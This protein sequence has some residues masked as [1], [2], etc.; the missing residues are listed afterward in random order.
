MPI[1][2]FY[3]FVYL[4]VYLTVYSVCKSNATTQPISNFKDNALIHSSKCCGIDEHLILFNNTVKCSKHTDNNNRFKIVFATISNY[5]KNG[6]C[7]E[8]CIDFLEENGKFQLYRL[9]GAMCNLEAIQKYNYF[10]K[11]CPPDFTY[12]KSTHKCVHGNSL[13]AFGDYLQVMKIG[14]S[15]C[16]VHDYAVAD[17]EGSF[18]IDND[19]K[20]IRMKSGESFNYGEFCIDLKHDMEKYLVRA[21]LKSDVICGVDKRRCLWKC[22]PDGEI[23]IQQQNKSKKCYPS[24]KSEINLNAISENV[25][26]NN[27]GMKL[28][29]LHFRAIIYQTN[30]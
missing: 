1:L 14:L 21:C 10:P 9:F 7:E 5:S 3:N 24:L 25:F 19:K 26:G 27:E 16:P 11:C 13:P 17:F 30:V 28:Q 6:D 23:Y 12:D 8:D 2:S 20:S 15:E 22:C 18:D 4:L 29:S